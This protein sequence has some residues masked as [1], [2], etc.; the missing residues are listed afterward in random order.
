MFRGWL[1][2]AGVELTNTSRLVAHARPGIPQTMEEAVGQCVCRADYVSY[3]DSWPGL[4][5]FLGDDPYVIADAPWY[6][7]AIPQSAELLG[8]W[9]TKIDGWGPTPVSRQVDDAIGPGGVAGPHRDQYRTLNIEF[10]IVACTNAGAVYGLEWLACRLRP[11]KAWGGTTLEFLAAHP[12]NSAAV[13]ASLR[14]VMNRVTVTQ[15]PE[16]TQS[17]GTRGEQNRQGNLFAGNFSLAVLDPYVYGPVTSATVVW[18]STVTE[19]IT[20][21]HAPDC[22]NPNSCDEIP[23]LASVE[24]V[25]ATVDVRPVQPPVCAGCTPLCAVETSVYEIPTAS[26]VLCVD[27]AVTVIVT[28]GDDPVSVNFWFRPCGE[29]ALCDRT[30]FLSVAGLPAGAT[31]VADS[32]QGRPY[33]IVDGTQIQQRGIV[34]TPSGAPW[35]AVV[36]DVGQCWELV[37]QHEPGL[38]F[39]VQVQVR[40]RSA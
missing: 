6:D 37:A 32:V 9:V 30:G 2:L 28:A 20:W 21:A 1:A 23:I 24:C 4:Q 3:D 14:R 33:S 16:V 22:A 39:T 18:D 26:G 12:E 31:V 7:P 40:G 8:F 10:S 25:P 29:T 19:Q 17:R 27:Q 5:A 36:L 34:S 38:D 35:T 11:A 15:A 13:P